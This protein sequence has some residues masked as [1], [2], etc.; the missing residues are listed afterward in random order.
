MKNSLVVI[1]LM[2]ALIAAPA[3]A[4][5]IDF[6]STGTP[7]DYNGL[8][9]TID[10][11]RFNWTLDNIDISASGWAGTG[12]AHSGA[13]AALNNYGGAG[14]IAREDGGTFSFQSLWV[15]NWFN[16]GDRNGA[17][18]GLLNGA[19][20][21]TV[22]GTSN[23]TWNQVTA[24]F[25]AIDT[26][27]IDFGNHFLIDDIVLDAANDVP[28]PGSLALLGLGLAGLAAHTRKARA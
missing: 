4:T 28:E 13:F 17:V 27:R 19:V 11:F 22:S 6:E 7:G 16:G 8:E 21:G 9:Y 14:E 1:G 2:A 20:V 3:S 23:G 18:V 24:N 5:V 15:H 10:G 26:L 12:P 25:A